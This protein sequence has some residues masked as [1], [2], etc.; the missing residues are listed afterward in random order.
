MKHF[1][2][3]TLNSVDKM[4]IFTRLEPQ[5]HHWDHIQVTNYWT[6]EKIGTLEP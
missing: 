1:I 2:L 4:D 5:R 6:W 3:I